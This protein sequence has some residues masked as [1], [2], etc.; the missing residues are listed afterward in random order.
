LPASIDNADCPLVEERI[1]GFGAHD[2]VV[3]CQ[4]VEINLRVSL[5]IDREAADVVTDDRAE[6]A[7]P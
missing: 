3:G 2:T 6:R 1:A 4:W 7:A 5:S